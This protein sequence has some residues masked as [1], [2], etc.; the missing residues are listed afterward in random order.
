M[1]KAEEF[2]EKLSISENMV[3]SLKKNEE[4]FLSEKFEISTILQKE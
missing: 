3:I 4:K 1:K 2:E